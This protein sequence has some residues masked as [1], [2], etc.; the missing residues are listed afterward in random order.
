M[1]TSVQHVYL[2]VLRRS[3]EIIQADR[4]IRLYCSTQL[5]K[6][7]R[8]LVVTLLGTGDV[9][10]GSLLQYPDAGGERRCQARWIFH[11]P[12]AHSSRVEVSQSAYQVPSGLSRDSSIPVRV[13]RQLDSCAQYRLDLSLAIS[14]D[15]L[16][17]M[18]GFRQS[19]NVCIRPGAI[20]ERPRGP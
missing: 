13:A 3:A 11:H 9:A 19:T 1:K 17:Y 4:A 2:M 5:P 10:C 7:R 16:P 18:F 15:L 12:I 20:V 6:S 14:N 8:E